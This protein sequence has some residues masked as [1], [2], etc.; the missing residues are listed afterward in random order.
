MEE[1]KKLVDIKENQ[2]MKLDKQIL[3]HLLKDKTTDRNIMWCTDNYKKHGQKYEYDQAIAINLI[4]SRNGNIIKPRVG[5]SK[6]E[7]KKRIKDKAEVFTPSWICNKQNNLIDNAW[8][9]R[10][11]VFNIETENGWTS[12][13]EKIDFPK[14]TGKGWIDY[15]ELNR[16]EVSCGEAPYIT[17]RYDTVSGNYIEVPDRIGLLDRK[18][19]IIGENTNN[20]DD[21]LKWAYRAVQSIYGFDWQGDNL[22]IARE[23]ILVD[24]LE[25]FENKFQKKIETSHL[26]EFAKIISWNIWQM[27]G[28]KF[29]VPGSCSK[30]IIEHT[31]FG[32][33]IISVECDGC[34]KGNHFNHNGIYC[35]IM[36]WK[37]HKTI[38]YVDL[39]R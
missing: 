18:L 14:E 6:H 8:F 35:K 29:V 38:R 20:E 3:S 12:T 23:N 15:V 34:K 22:L 17:S 27:D 26:I 36:D 37:T 10:E 24:V 33:E 21:W 4:T 2:L 11:N 28:I 39:L 5:K 7:Q 25:Y 19:R 31:L 1:E 32:E 9:K 30:S 16:M 13:N